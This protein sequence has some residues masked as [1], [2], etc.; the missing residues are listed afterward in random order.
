M[1]VSLVSLVAGLVAAAIVCA[2]MLVFGVAL[3]RPTGERRGWLVWLAVLGWLCVALAG[4]LLVGEQRFRGSTIVVGYCVLMALAGMSVVALGVRRTRGENHPRCRTC[5]FDL[6][7]K[8]PSSTLCGACGSDLTDVRAVVRS[9]GRSVSL[10]SAGLMLIAGAVLVGFPTALAASHKPRGAFEGWIPRLYAYK[11]LTWVVA[12][13]AKSFDS[14]SGWMIPADRL[15]QWMGDPRQRQ[16]VIRAIYERAVSDHAKTGRPGSVGQYILWDDADPGLTNDEMR[17]LL[18]ASLDS[19]L[20]LPRSIA[21]GRAFQV[22]LVQFP[23][24]MSSSRVSGS[25]ELL[26]A[27]LNGH[28]VDRI[29]KDPVARFGWWAE[30]TSSWTH[31]GKGSARFE[32]VVRA[33]LIY[34]RAAGETLSEVVD[35]SL[36]GQTIV[37]DAAEVFPPMIEPTSADQAIQWSARVETSDDGELDVRLIPDADPSAPLHGNV[38]LRQGDRRHLIAYE[39]LGRLK[40]V[41]GMWVNI[42]AD[43]LPTGPFELL[44]EPDPTAPV[45]ISK[46]ND[47]TPVLNLSFAVTVDRRGE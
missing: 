20:T 13:L 2:A 7:G 28:P 37:V 4:A 45:N 22:G 11:P 9:G 46:A 41:E 18:R 34:T 29:W 35:V 23:V 3:R 26:N 16:R 25:S 17:K 43:T 30:P 27:T 10:A 14:P 8:P 33:T 15:D 44:F 6:F 31:I 47:R 19:R 24:A 32:L 21:D 36:V 40:S 39:R 1:G 38:F 5:G 12:D 42:P